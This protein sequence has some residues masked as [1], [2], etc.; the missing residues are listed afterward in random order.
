M[1]AL[2]NTNKLIAKSITNNQY[3]FAFRS[4]WVYLLAV[5]DAKDAYVEKM[6]WICDNHQYLKVDIHAYCA[7]QSGTERRFDFYVSQISTIPR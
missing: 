5:P 1:G 7:I 4:T 2:R 3:R 6:K